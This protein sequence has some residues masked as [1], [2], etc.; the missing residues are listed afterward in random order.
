MSDRQL[1]DLRLRVYNA[2]DED[3]PPA[4]GMMNQRLVSGQA[5]FYYE[6]SSSKVPKLYCRFIG[7]DGNRCDLETE[8]GI[9]TLPQWPVIQ[10]LFS[11][12]PLA[13]D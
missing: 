4:A 6:N 5:E 8:N 2:T 13:L 12:T 11:E 1:V 10:V 3:H 9:I 7:I